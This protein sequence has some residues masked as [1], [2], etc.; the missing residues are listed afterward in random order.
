MKHLQRKMISLPPAIQQ[1]INEAL[2]QVESHY[3]HQLRPST[4][5]TQI[6]STMR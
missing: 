3:A 2:T 5:R 1:K 6:R 4:R